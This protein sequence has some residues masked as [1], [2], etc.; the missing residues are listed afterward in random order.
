MS[1]L[2]AILGIASMWLCG[3]EGGR[4]AAGFVLGIGVQL[5]WIGYAIATAQYGF[6]IGAVVYGSVC[7]RNLVKLRAALL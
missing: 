7:V 3:E 5:I 1:Y 4:R 2:I 6:V